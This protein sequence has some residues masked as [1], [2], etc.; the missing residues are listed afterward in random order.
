[1]FVLD[2]RTLFFVALFFNTL[3]AIGMFLF[4]RRM[5]VL[6]SLYYLALADGLMGGSTLLFTLRN[7]VDQFWSV[8]V[9]NTL[10]V[11]GLAINY[12]AI[13]KFRGIPRRRNWVYLLLLGALHGIVFGY[14]TYIEPNV[15]AR[16][17]FISLEF[18]LAFT[19]FAE[20]LY[21][22]GEGYQ[23]LGSR[24]FAAIFLVFGILYIVRAVYSL[25]ES[26]IQSFMNAGLVHCLAVIGVIVFVASKNFLFVYATAA[27]MVDTL[28]KLSKIDPLTQI[29]NR[30]GLEE[31]CELEI[32]R[33]ER[34]GGELS[35]I[36]CDLDL[37]KSVN[38]YYG[39]EAGDTVLKS[40][41]TMIKGQIRS[42][43]ICARIGGEEFIV[44]LPNTKH[45]GA[46]RLAGSLKDHCSDIAFSFNK[47]LKITA[48]FGVAT[49]WEGMAL[50]RLMQLADQAM[51]QAKKRGRNQVCSAKELEDSEISVADF[52]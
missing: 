22:K 30:R 36:L 37:F 33:I 25:E 20:L 50:T 34:Y 45:S 49:Y 13:M 7:V 39:H 19:L 35:V 32:A 31:L 42:T 27:T 43:D 10:M 23:Y 8:V 4:A 21:K 1:M 16:I 14:Y 18:A 51:Y 6:S 24:S 46:L 3:Y 48:S 26:P 38:D 52:A 41:A 28:D 15:N 29:L 9:A 12:F 2:I 17:V 40:F 11:A 5:K 44:V 47:E